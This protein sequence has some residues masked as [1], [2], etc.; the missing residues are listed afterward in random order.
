MEFEWGEKKNQE[1]IKKHGISFEYASYVF[2]DEYL[3]EEYDETHS[4][5]EDRYDVIG[6]V[7]D[8]LFV[9][10]TYREND[11]IIRL[12]SARVAIKAERNKYYGNR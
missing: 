6:M 12:I 2:D 3:V 9:V 11:K 10:C 8:V 7:D 1:N 4:D 5:D